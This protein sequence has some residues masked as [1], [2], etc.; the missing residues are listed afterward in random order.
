M[1]GPT[2]TEI[3]AA[4]NTIK[5]HLD[6]DWISEGCGIEYHVMGCASCQAVHLKR[7]L[8]GLASFLDENSE[9]SS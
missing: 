7:E 5:A 3:L 6:A 8:D 1:N 2:N 4:I 9:K